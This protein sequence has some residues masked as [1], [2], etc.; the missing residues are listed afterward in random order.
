MRLVSDWRRSWRYFSTQ[1]LAA[2]ALIPLV[3]EQ[4]PPDVQAI[5]PEAWRPWILAL[6]ALGG[7][8]GR[9]VDQGD[10]E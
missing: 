8:A 7:M 4:F 2:L 6:V 3:W 9:L 10:A 1:A 5:I